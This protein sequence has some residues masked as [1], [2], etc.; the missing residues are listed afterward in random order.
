MQQPPNG[1]A[2]ARDR[3]SR[4]P[5][6]PSHWELS[7]PDAVIR[8]TERRPIRAVRREPWHSGDHA[9]RRG[10]G[11][12]DRRVRCGGER[13]A[14]THALPPECNSNNYLMPCR[15][16]ARTVRKWCYAFS[17]AQPH[18]AGDHAPSRAP[19]I[20]VATRFCAECPSN[21]RSTLARGAFVPPVSRARRVIAPNSGSGTRR[22]KHRR[23]TR[24]GPA[25]VFCSAVGQTAGVIPPPPAGS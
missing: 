20:G 8:T 12:V 10:G 19:S 4:L 18:Q 9:T 22:R 6:T 7:G 15:D 14:R 17:P 1:G 23:P 24:G 13:P 21:D 16:F 11:S 5:G 3:T 25:L 2:L